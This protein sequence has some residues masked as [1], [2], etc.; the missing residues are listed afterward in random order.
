MAKTRKTG[1]RSKTT[2]SRQRSKA[3]SNGSGRDDAIK[4]LKSDHREVERLFGS[5]ESTRSQERKQELAAQ[6]CTA[7]KTHMTIEE[8]ILYP[9]FLEATED[10]EIHH[11]AEIEHA[12]AKHLIQEIE[13]AGPKDD[14]FEARVTVLEEMI[15]HHVKEEEQRGGMFMKAQSSDMDLAELG[16]QLRDRKLELMGDDSEGMATSRRRPP[17][18]SRTRRGGREL[19]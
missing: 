18:P 16:R 13:S 5:F 11:E 19:R 12:G 14:H 7:L 3:A 9:A 8:E 6:I 17:L 4:L 2:Q 15:R 10:T 1:R